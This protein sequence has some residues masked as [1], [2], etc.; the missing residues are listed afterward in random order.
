M[1]NET[2]NFE[3][4]GFLENHILNIEMQILFWIFLESVRGSFGHYVGF[5][6]SFS[7]GFFEDSFNWNYKVFPEIG[8]YIED[9]LRGEYWE[10]N[11]S[12][13]RKG[14]LD[15]RILKEPQP[16]KSGRPK[17]K[18]PNIPEKFSKSLSQV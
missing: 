17:L 4:N 18:S 10:N 2:L 13:L 15:G 7:E 12:Y 6:F 16:P 3:W 8:K 9:C 1:E 14:F 11:N 5:T